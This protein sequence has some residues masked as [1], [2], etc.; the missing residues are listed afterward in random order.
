[1]VSIMVW[2]TQKSRRIDD[3]DSHAGKEILVAGMGE[4]CFLIFENG[5][6]EVLRSDFEMSRGRCLLTVI[7][8]LILTF[9][10]GCVG[11]G[12]Y[13][14]KLPNGYSI[15]RTSAHNVT[16][17]PQE[18]ENSW[19][20]PLIP[21]KVVQVGWDDRYILAK[22]IGL[23]TDPRSSNGNQI[24]DESNVKFWIMEMK[25]K[26]VI[27]PLDEKEFLNKKIELSISN[28][29]VLQDIQK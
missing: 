6:T 5:V 29:L 27:G 22:Q 15:V 8:L 7:T 1:M 9:I 19:G 25:T 2:M 4:I 26:K 13:D 28:E 24:P 3:N 10:T 14:I 20:A 11:L 23:K 16:I 12:D 21:T 17:S 18:S